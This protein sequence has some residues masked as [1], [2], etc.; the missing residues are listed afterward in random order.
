MTLVSYQR[1]GVTQYVILQELV[2]LVE[3]TVLHQSVDDQLIQVVLQ[4]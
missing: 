1:L 3:S 2:Q 4:S